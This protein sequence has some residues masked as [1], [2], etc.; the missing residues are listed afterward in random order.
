MDFSFLKDAFELRPVKKC[1]RDCRKK[2]SLQENFTTSSDIQQYDAAK[3]AQ[4]HE[5]TINQSLGST[6]T[7][8]AL[9]TKFGSV[10]SQ[11]ASDQQEMKAQVASYIDD[12][13]AITTRLSN[14]IRMKRDGAAA[15]IQEAASLV[16]REE[17]EIERAARIAGELDALS[18]GGG[19]QE[20]KNLQNYLAQT[21][22][23]LTD[24]NAELKAA[25]QNLASI[26]TGDAA[27]EGKLNIEWQKDQ[28]SATAARKLADEQET[29]VRN[30]FNQK[31]I[32]VQI[33]NN[34]LAGINSEFNTIEA[35]IT[36][37]QT[38]LR[39]GDEGGYFD[40]TS[41][42]QTLDNKHSIEKQFLK[43]GNNTLQTTDDRVGKLY[44]KHTRLLNNSDLIKLPSKM[45][46]ANQSRELQKNAHSMQKLK[47]DLSSSSKN[48]QIKE[49][50]NQKKMYY[51]F[52][53]KH[54]FISLIVVLI[55]AVLS[56]T[57]YISNKLSN[58]LIGLIFTVLAGLIGI[59]FFV[60]RDRN[61]IYFKKRDFPIPEAVM[62][63]VEN[64]KCAI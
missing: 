3:L 10:R 15:F 30:K 38:S 43:T 27:E 21:K 42:L 36:A 44:N 54:V 26:A 60:N 24:S 31:Y 57:G 1:S 9:Q 64:P 34:E 23:K 13:D 51:I 18:G 45:L 56:R 4:G 5:I 7:D 37:Q 52:L 2:C 25:V 49:N 32:D 22:S 46:K 63:P 11:L 20:L 29:A 48:I 16:A 61:D 59:N 47:T 35:A 53:L 41:L 50:Y 8:T 17:R 28:S 12:K 58:I 62:P 6:P 19:G 14:N 40:F 55:V 33:L 39:N